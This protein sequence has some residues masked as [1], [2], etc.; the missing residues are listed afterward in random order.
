MQSLKRPE[1]IAQS[2]VLS[3]EINADI[4]A[5]C[6]D[7]TKRVGRLPSIVLKNHKR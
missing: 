5:R 1:E 2:G 3:A 6:H 4:Q 7:L